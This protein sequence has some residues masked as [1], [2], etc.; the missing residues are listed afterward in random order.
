MRSKILAV[1]AGGSGER[2]WP[3]S[4]PERP[5]QLL[6]LTNPNQSML[7]EAVWRAVTVVGPENVFIATSTPL[8]EPVVDARIV[9]ETHVFAEPDRRNTLG[10][11][12]WLGANLI[13]QGRQDS[14]VG[15]LTAD[16][17]IGDAERFARALADCLD[18]A[19]SEDAI[20]TLGIEPDRPETGYG[21]IEADPNRPAPCASGRTAFSSLGFREKPDLATAQEFVASGRYYWNGGMF[22][23]PIS[24]LLQEIEASQPEAYALLLEIAGHLKSSNRAAANEAFSRLASISFDYAV[25]ERASRVLV[26]PADFP[27]DDVG[28]WDSLD[29]TFPA[30]GNGN[31]VQGGGIVLDS[32]NTIVLNDAPHR[33]QVGVLGVE[34][35]VVVVTE[36]SVLVCAKDRAQD[37]R[38]IAQA[39]KEQA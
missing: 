17:R 21:Y 2:F 7:E 12:V 24:R 38:K 35:L 4:R 13:A 19:E 11:V 22:F 36:D 10:C 16:H 20:V 34:N 32:S 5:K 39:I 27:W 9:P 6:R 23:F 29:R 30:D 37:V 14:V 28:S 26:V 31:V 18:L 3:L 8:Y 33:I 25:M 1:M 15:L